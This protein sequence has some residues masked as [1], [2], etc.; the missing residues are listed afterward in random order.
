MLFKRLVLLSVW[1][2]SHLRKPSL[3]AQ[4][5]DAEAESLYERSQAIRERVLG[6]EHADV[7][8]V[9][10]NQVGVD[11]DAAGESHTVVGSFHESR[12]KEAFENWL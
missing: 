6:P 8:T 1:R 5:K 2:F 9:L 7:A 4:G 11:G 10:D 12:L 3:A